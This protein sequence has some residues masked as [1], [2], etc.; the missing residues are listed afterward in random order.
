MTQYIKTTLNPGVVVHT[1]NPSTCKAKKGGLS[2]QS[3]LLDTARPCLKK[4]K[5]RNKYKIKTTLNITW[6]MLSKY[7]SF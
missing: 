5:T 3:Q 2:I 4:N 7:V 1:C 6:H